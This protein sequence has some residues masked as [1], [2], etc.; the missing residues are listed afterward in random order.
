MSVAKVGMLSGA[1]CRAGT[2]WRRNMSELGQVRGDRSGC[3]QHSHWNRFRAGRA[4][5]LVDDLFGLDLQALAVMRISLGIYRT[6]GLVGA[7]GRACVAGTA[8][9]GAYRREAILERFDGGGFVP[10][11]NGEWQFNAV[12]FLIHAVFAAMF[13]V[14][15]RARGPVLAVRHFAACSGSI[16]QAGDV[17]LRLAVV[18]EHVPA[19]ARCSVDAFLMPSLKRA[20]ERVVN[21][22]TAAFGYQLAAVYPRPAQV[23]AGLEKWHRDLLCPQHRLL[24]QAALR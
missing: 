7:L 8:P 20:P 13:L 9:I 18:L 12:L 11:V 19:G 22:A 1:S 14:N 5:R 3:G 24:R 6:A 16:R 23:R 10:L 2:R 17:V 4:T 15:T 21:L